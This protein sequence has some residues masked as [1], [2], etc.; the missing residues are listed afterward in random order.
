ML[1]VLGTDVPRFG[2]RSKRG[3]LIGKFPVGTRVMD[4]LQ[5]IFRS[6]SNL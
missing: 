6:V 2:L 4:F 1:G 5:R 3:V